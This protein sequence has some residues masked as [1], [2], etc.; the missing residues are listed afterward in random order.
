MR[1]TG[2]DDLICDFA[3]YYH[4]CDMD[5]LTVR[6]AAILACGLPKESRTI[7][8]YSGE[9]QDPDELYKLSLFDLLRK[10]EFALWQTHSTKKLKRPESLVK[11]LLDQGN[12]KN[13]QVKGFASPEE[14][15]AAWNRE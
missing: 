10:I 3:Q 2:Q 8:R 14:F 15:E 6:T 11:K 12:K 9:K 1:A 13:Q 7:K 5:S 4:I